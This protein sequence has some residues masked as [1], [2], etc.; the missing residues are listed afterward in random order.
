ML[1][2]QGLTGATIDAIATEAGVARSTIYRNWT[3]RED[4]LAAAFDDAIDPPTVPP[5]D[6]P[7]R[8]QL[9]RI[10]RDLA[11]S[12]ERSEWGRALPAVVAAIDVEPELADRYGRLTRERR[13][14]MSAVLADA[15]DRGE[16]PRGTRL[17]DLVDALVGPL[18]YR[19]LVRRTSTGAAWITRHVD[20]TLTGVTAR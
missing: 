12:L 17:D 19:R 4:L 10:L 1:R 14:A 18:F 2:Q 20:R 11:T 3:T 6:L 5:A 13:A 8:D 16:L 7:L 9:E 15:V